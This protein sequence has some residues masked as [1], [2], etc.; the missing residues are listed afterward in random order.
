MEKIE[1]EGKNIIELAETQKVVELK[2]NFARELKKPN[3]GSF[4]TKMKRIGGALALAGI[5]TLSPRTAIAPET[6]EEYRIAKSGKDLQK[7]ALQNEELFKRVDRALEET[8]GIKVSPQLETI[9]K[10]MPKITEMLAMG[11]V[12]NGEIPY[13]S[14]PEII[15]GK[16]FI[17][18]H[19]KEAKEYLDKIKKTMQATVIVF[20]GD[21][22]A[23]SGSI[24]DTGERSIIITNQHVAEHDEGDFS[25]VTAN[26]EKFKTRKAFIDR[27]KDLA[28][29]ET[30]GNFAEALKAKKVT[31]LKLASK[32]TLEKLNFGDKLAAVG[33]PLGFPFE[34]ATAE[35]TDIAKIIHHEPT[36]K[37]IRKNHSDAIFS[38]P[39]PRFVK[40]QSYDSKTA[41]VPMNVKKGNF[42]GGMSGGP[43]IRLGKTGEPE[44][45]GITTINTYDPVADSEGELIGGAINAVNIQKHLDEYNAYLK[46][47]K[48]K[49][50]Y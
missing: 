48:S 50:E 37:G 5:T 32:E 13:F 16:E 30:G 8:G 28:V 39:D 17:D 44:I 27:D 10:V 1:P 15:L 31:A 3:G 29:L 40:L 6:T 38:R 43:V 19:P 7:I 22:I 45:I 2:K 18:K 42:L 9:Y 4:L 24:I 46:A 34:V 35:Y 12:A 23:G 20:K 41:K 26:G 14:K 11:R 47:P 25:F 36:L 49:G 21:E 33:H